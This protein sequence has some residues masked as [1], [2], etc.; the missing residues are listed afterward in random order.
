MFSPFIAGISYISLIND[1]NEIVPAKINKIS[2]IDAL[3]CSLDVNVMKYNVNITLPPINCMEFMRCRKLLKYHPYACTNVTLKMN[4][5]YREKSCI[6][7]I[8]SNEDL[9]CFW[10]HKDTL[11]WL[12]KGILETVILIMFTM[13]T[14]RI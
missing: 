12:I 10:S 5:W 3:Q 7:I 13:F 1:C 4:H 9:R 8:R 2:N 6:D 11:Q 14:T